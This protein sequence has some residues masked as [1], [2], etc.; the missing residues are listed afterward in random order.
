MIFNSSLVVSSISLSLIAITLSPNEMMGKTAQPMD[1]RFSI[2][3]VLNPVTPSINHPDHELGVEQ[4]LLRERIVILT[5]EI[6]SESAQRIV[7]QL[8]YLDRK[9][10]GTDIYLYINSEGGHITSGLAIYDTIRS[11]QSDVV[12]VSVG[13]SSSMASFLLA[14]G[15]KGKR[16][17]LPNS[18]IM[19]H[20]P[21]WGVFGQASEVE[22]AAKEILYLKNLLNRLLAELT[23]QS[24]R[25]IEI[26]TDRDFFMSAQEAKIYGIVDK[27]VNQLPSAS[28]PLNE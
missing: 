9:A 1:L 11:L 20:Q 12:T 7:F 24:L 2:A 18:R 8:I 10:P 6:T 17:A 14:S 5:G 13:E 25:Q 21:V 22:I 3:Q 27:V 4:W 26:D 28:H 19:I 16:F 15:T 23:G